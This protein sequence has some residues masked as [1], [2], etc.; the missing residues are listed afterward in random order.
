MTSI[1]TIQVRAMRNWQDVS[2]L[3][4]KAAIPKDP[5]QQI[6]KLVLSRYHLVSSNQKRAF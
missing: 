6:N 5:P 2:I 4:K 1:K 3:L